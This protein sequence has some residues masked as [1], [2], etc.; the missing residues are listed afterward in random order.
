M[1]DMNKYTVEDLAKITNLSTLNKKIVYTTEQEFFDNM[2]Q[3]LNSIKEFLDQ[4]SNNKVFL[5]IFD[6]YNYTPQGIVNYKDTIEQDLINFCFQYPNRIDIH[7]LTVVELEYDNLHPQIHYWY[8]PEFHAYYWELFRDVELDLDKD[9]T[10]K[11]VCLNKRGDPWRQGLYKKFFYE[12]MILDNYF[13]FLCER[14]NGEDLFHIPT[15]RENQKFLD[16]EYF[17]QYFPELAE[18][19]W[20][21]SMFYEIHDDPNFNEYKESHKNPGSDIGIKDT[22]WKAERRFYEDTFISIIVETSV[23]HE[24]VNVSEKIF[25]SIAIGH[26]FFVAGVHGTVQLLR[27]LGFDTFDDIFDT[28][29]DTIDESFERMAVWYK[30]IDKFTSMSVEELNALKKTL[31]PRLIANRERFKRFYQEYLDISHKHVANLLKLAEDY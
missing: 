22:T 11:F 31:K 17:V 21:P 26:P 10:K 25:R 14:D 18:S 2:D 23:T 28:Q 6:H 29:Y 8:F 3:D 5:M 24:H 4:D 12:G 1:V 13:S 20:A 30:S 19:D 7:F 16:E 27:D 15:F 9:I